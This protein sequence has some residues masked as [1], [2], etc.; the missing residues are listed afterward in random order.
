M[1]VCVLPGTELSFADEVRITRRNPWPDVINYK[2]AIFRQI[3]QDDPRAHHDAL[4]FPNGDSVLWA[5][6]RKVSRPPFFS[7]RLRLLALKP[8]NER[9]TFN[10]LSVTPTEKASILRPIEALP[11]GSGAEASAGRSSA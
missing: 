7:Y 8:R 4:E 6:R 10:P 2:T 11:V 9:P 5:P 1:A 3:N